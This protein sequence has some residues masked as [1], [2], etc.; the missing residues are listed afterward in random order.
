MAFSADR[1]EIRLF[2]GISL[3]NPALHALLAMQKVVG[4]NP[5]SRSR[6]SPAI[7]GFFVPDGGFLDHV[8]RHFR[9]R[10]LIQSSNVAPDK[11]HE[12]LFARTSEGAFELVLGASAHVENLLIDPPPACQAR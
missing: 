2:A 10:V 8:S 11:H 12:G 6:K 9:G 1:G 5:I 3:Q 4:S 7:A